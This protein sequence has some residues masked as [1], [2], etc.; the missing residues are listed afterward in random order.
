MSEAF[1]IST[2]EALY[3]EQGAKG[4]VDHIRGW[5]DGLILHDNTSS[6]VRSVI[7]LLNDGRWDLEEPLIDFED[8]RTFE[9]VK[10]EVAKMLR[11]G[12]TLSPELREL[13]AQFVMGEVRPK[14]V[15][16][17]RRSISTPE[18]TLTARIF[19]KQLSAI[20]IP[21]ILSE[22]WGGF[23]RDTGSAIIAAALGVGEKSVKKWIV[24]QRAFD[25]GTID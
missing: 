5:R 20:G 6:H 23:D 15:R 24:A 16:G 22:D 10:V 9:V 14:N 11:A 4:L 13:A 1:S 2:L 7:R 3:K 12:A 8:P 21:A 17:P 19:L 18:N 25:N